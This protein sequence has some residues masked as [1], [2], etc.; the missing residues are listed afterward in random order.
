MICRA[1]YAI[2]KPGSEEAHALSWPVSGI[3]SSYIHSI[4][5][6]CSM[7]MSNHRY[8]M[9][10]FHFS[11]LRNWPDPSVSKI[12]YSKCGNAA[13]CG[14]PFAWSTT[15]YLSLVTCR[16]CLDMVAFHAEE[17]PESVVSRRINQVYGLEANHTFAAGRCT[18]CGCS[19]IAA[20]HFRWPCTK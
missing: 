5:R 11:N 8:S 3:G 4:D 1:F 19:E 16:R 9:Y 10:K 17:I 6:N 20:T 18:R 12:H 14:V 13:I 15:P 7:H 2:S